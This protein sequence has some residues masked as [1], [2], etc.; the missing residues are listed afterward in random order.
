MYSMGFS[1]ASR[2]SCSALVVLLAALCCKGP[3]GFR[4]LTYQGQQA[5]E[6]I[7]VLWAIPEEDYKAFLE[8]FKVFDKDTNEFYMNSTEDFTQ[9]R[10]YYK[11][12]NRL[13]TLGNV[14]KMYIPPIMDARKG[15]YENQIIFE[16]GFADELALGPGKRALEMGC[17]RGRITHHVASHTGASVIGMNIDS[18]QIQIA[19]AY[20]NETGLADRLSFVE[21]NMNDP[22]PF[23][24]ETFNAF[25]EVQALTYAQ[26]LRAVLREIHR[27]LKPGAKISL[28][29]GVMLDGY[30]GR[31]A[32]HRK[33]LR[34]TREVTGWGHFTH[35]SEWKAAIEDA[36]FHVL[37]SKD[38]SWSKDREGSQHML[39]LQ[40][41]RY[42][43]VLAHVVK[44]GA[45][46]GLIPVHIDTLI[47]RL[48]R[49]GESYME[50]DKRNMLTT[51]WHIIAQK[52]S[53]TGFGA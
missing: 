11:V 21:G 40:E 17:G 44:L 5:Y 49:H 9:V 48:N 51:S 12:L 31:D 15:V 33:L 26:D 18:M 27:V 46:L 10:N 23:P 29:D 39:I 34:E 2:I 32:G 50:M 8:S 1:S 42:F 38:P 16:A 53:D 37:Q 45:W 41:S 35:H 4:T 28:L 52:P 7:K 22:L 47:E 30:D 36:G 3:K 25:Y 20:A 19:N 6:A 14:E 43:W 13:C 24:N